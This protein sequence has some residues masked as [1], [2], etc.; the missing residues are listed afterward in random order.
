MFAQPWVLPHLDHGNPTSLHLDAVLLMFGAGPGMGCRMM[1]GQS[2]GRVRP[3]RCTRM[4]L[5][6]KIEPSHEALQHQVLI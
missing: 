2:L 6:G 3:H 1:Q 5:R 4:Q